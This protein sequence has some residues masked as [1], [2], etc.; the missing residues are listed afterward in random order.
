MANPINTTAMRRLPGIA[1]AAGRIAGTHGFPWFAA[2][3]YAAATCGSTDITAI[4]ET[5]VE[6]LQGWLISW[7]EA[8]PTEKPPPF[9][10]PLIEAPLN[11][12]L[13]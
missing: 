9:L 1:N 3:A 4:H 8:H 2:Y 5:A 12:W 13:P 10:K 11:R 7:A 6:W